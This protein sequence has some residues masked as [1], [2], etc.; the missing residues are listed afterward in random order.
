MVGDIRD[1]TDSEALVDLAH[2]RM[3]MDLGV[4]DPAVPAKERQTARSQQL[5]QP[6]PSGMPVGPV[7]RLRG[8]H[9]AER[10]VGGGEVVEPLLAHG[11]PLGETLASQPLLHDADHP[12][13]GFQSHY[14]DTAV[15]EGH[16]GPT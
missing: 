10:A 15:G 11:D 13:G 1:E 8:D 2:P 4:E 5:G 16:G 3:V 7:E 14:V 9:Q 6:A 12:R